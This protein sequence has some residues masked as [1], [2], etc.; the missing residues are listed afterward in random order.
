M[1]K[2]IQERKKTQLHSIFR[3]L[4]CA[5][6]NIF[7]KITIGIKQQIRNNSKGT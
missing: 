6:K 1:V 3:S 5:A 4:N 2:Y 7:L